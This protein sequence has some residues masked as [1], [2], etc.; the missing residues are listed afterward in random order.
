VSAG[1]LAAGA[2]TGWLACARASYALLTWRNLPLWYR[3]V[4]QYTNL[5]RWHTHRIESCYE[6]NVPASR[7]LR[8][9][10]AALLGPVVVTA[11]VTWAWVYA[12][13]KTA[14]YLITAGQPRTSLEREQDG[15]Q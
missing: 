9:V 12:V 14:D 5:E 6:V 11:A 8:T 7:C 1:I 3:R 10:T 13:L 4:C 2:A 15:E